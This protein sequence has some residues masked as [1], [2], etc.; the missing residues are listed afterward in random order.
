[1]VHVW[2]GGVQLHT[3]R[4][5]ARLQVQ[6]GEVQ[7]G[8]GPGGCGADMRQGLRE[9][10]GGRWQAHENNDNKMRQ[11]RGRPQRIKFQKLVRFH[12][13]DEGHHAQCSCT[14]AMLQ[15]SQAG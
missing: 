13:V 3:D 9:G 12:A 10:R 8:G 2:A 7:G 1:M 6:G 11:V 15:C 4:V 14:R 5:D